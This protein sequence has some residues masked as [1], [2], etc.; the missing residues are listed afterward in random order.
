MPYQ[1]YKVMHL[2]AIFVFLSSAAVLLLS[3]KKTKFWKILTGI[4]SFVILFAGMGLV[5]RLYPS[6]NGGGGFSQPWV[7]A[8]IVIW[9]AVTALGHLVAKRFPG[10]GMKAYWATM[11]LAVLAAGLAIYKPA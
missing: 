11:I 4:S 9:V 2:A 1:V 3:D 10:F 8:K 5:A 6:A 7:Q